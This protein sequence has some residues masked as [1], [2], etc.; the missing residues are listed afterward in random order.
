M[1]EKPYTLLRQN[2][3]LGRAGMNGK[4]TLRP[5]GRSLWAACRSFSEGGLR[6]TESSAFVSGCLAR[7][8]RELHFQERV[9]LVCLVY[10]VCLVERN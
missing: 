2:A 10:L 1:V 8:R 7:E 5:V 4:E 6:A 9:D 3:L